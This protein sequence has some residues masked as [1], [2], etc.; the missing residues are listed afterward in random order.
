MCFHFFIRTPSVG[1]MGTVSPLLNRRTDEAV[2]RCRGRVAQDTCQNGRAAVGSDAH[3]C[4]GSLHSLSSGPAS[5]LSRPRA[6]WVDMI[7]T[8][9]TL[10]NDE[11]RY[12]LR[13]GCELSEAREGL[14]RNRKDFK[15][16]GSL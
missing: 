15:R 1:A 11:S 13:S 8:K 3:I 16:W 12:L 5:A 2:G 7:Q 6:C 14:W 10:R 4:G 9:E